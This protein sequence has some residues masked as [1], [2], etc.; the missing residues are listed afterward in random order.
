MKSVYEKFGNS[1][2]LS[3]ITKKIYDSPIYLNTH[4]RFLEQA[5]HEI[6]NKFHFIMLIYILF[7]LKLT[8]YKV[9]LL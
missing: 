3:R 6:I 2:T 9:H 7:G 1:D 8:H 5:V 4:D